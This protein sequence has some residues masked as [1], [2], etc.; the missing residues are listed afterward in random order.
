[1]LY[2]LTMHSR[3]QICHEFRS[4]LIHGALAPLRF[5]DKYRVTAEANANNIASFFTPISYARR[6]ISCLS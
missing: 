2:D 5:R 1:M 3:R 4:Y 6:T